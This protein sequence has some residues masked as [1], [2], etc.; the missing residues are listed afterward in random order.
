MGQ[1]WRSKNGEGMGASQNG[2]KVVR[3]REKGTETSHKAETSKTK[4]TAKW[5]GM[6]RTKRN[7]G[8]Q[9]IENGT[10]TSKGKDIRN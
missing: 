9:W 10:E 6:R 7:T 4:G 8:L 2:T 1:R 3:R 5:V